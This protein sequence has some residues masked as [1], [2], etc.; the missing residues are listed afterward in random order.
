LIETD[1]NLFLYLNE[2]FSGKWA[3]IFFSVITHL[4]NGLVTA[5]LVIAFMYLFK[6]KK[7]CRHF[8]PMVLSVA[9]AGAVVN[10]IKPV[11]NRPRPANYFAGTDVE[12]HTPKGTPSDKSFPS[13][14]TMAAFGAATYLSCLYPAASPVFLGLAALTGLSRIALGV[15]YPSDVLVGALFGIVFSLAGFRWYRSYMKRKSRERPLEC[16][17]LFDIDGTLVGSPAGRTSTGSLAMND[18]SIEIARRPARFSG[19]DYAGRTDILIARMLL[20][21]AGVSSPS[22]DKIDAFIKSYLTHLAERIPEHPSCVLGNPRAAIEALRKQGATVG[23]GTGNVR[24]GA[25]LKLDSAKIG[26]LFEPLL[27]GFGEDGETRGELLEAGARLLDPAR[28]LPVIIVGDT[29]KDVEGAKT[30]GAM[31]IGVPFGKNDRAVLKAAG[32]DAVTDT[33]DESLVDVVYELLENSKGE[34][35]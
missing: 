27:G 5:L 26:D 35:R 10:V 24:S 12:V 28:R 14:H 31:C 17:V 2:L 7:L 11:V 9:A 22:K 29:P 34:I 30:I 13:G 15:H 32:A 1:I 20:E 21:D 4:G 3:S 25:R 23:L 8:L 19:S 33:L 16:V 18:A 6:A